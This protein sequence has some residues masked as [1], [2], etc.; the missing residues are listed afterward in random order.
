MENEQ[1][2]EAQRIF[3]RKDLRDKRAQK[4]KR[5]ALDRIRGD[6]VHLSHWVDHERLIDE[7]GTLMQE[8]PDDDAQLGYLVRYWVNT[9]ML[10]EA[11]KQAERKMECEDQ[12]TEMLS[13]LLNALY[14]R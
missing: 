1:L 12:V 2:K 14:G 13:P 4:L 5:E 8:N 7:I 9:E 11:H 3:D 10:I 6:L